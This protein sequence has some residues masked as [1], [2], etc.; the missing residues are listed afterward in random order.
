MNA[1]Q[2]D[3]TAQTDNDQ[4]IVIERRPGW[5]ILNLKELLDY[6]DLFIFMVWREIKVLYAQTILGLSWAILEPLVQ[7]L[8]FTV[9]FGRVAKINTDGIP[10]FVFST[11]AIIPWTYMQQ[12]MNMSSQSLISGQNML[13]KIYFPRFIFPLTPIFAR[14]VDF[15]IS[16][17]ILVCV[18]FYYKIPLTLNIIYLPI[19]LLMMMAVPTS[20]GLWLS[21]MAI[22]FRD[23][24]F[25][26][27]F[28]VRMLIYTAPIVYSASSIPEKYRLIYS[29]NPIVG[30]IEGFRNCILGRPIAWPFILPGMFTVAIL[31]L[32][33]AYYFKK[34]EEIIVDVI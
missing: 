4:V 9:V 31:L 34:M 12:A 22:R 29:L 28:V 33:G 19:F 32:T 15:L 17:L 6:R 10:Y 14:M 7:I 30:I 24:K 23:V 1:M 13:G 18:L 5:K 26:M 2:D 16:L 20:I 27:P 8:I 21:S 3:L 11:A 25:A